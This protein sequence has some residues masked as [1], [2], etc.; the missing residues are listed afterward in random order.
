M[1]N[2]PKW[3]FPY[4]EAVA[5]VKKVEAGSC[6]LSPYGPVCD[7][8][9]RFPKAHGKACKPL[10]V[11]K[12]TI[13]KVSCDRCEQATQGCGWTNSPVSKKQSKG[14]G[15][16]LKRVPEGS[17]D[18]D[19]AVVKPATKKAK[20]TPKKETR[21]AAQKKKSAAPSEVDVTS[22]VEMPGPSQTQATMPGKSTPLFLPSPESDA[23]QDVGFGVA[24]EDIWEEM[25]K[26]LEETPVRPPSAPI[27]GPSK[28][29]DKG[30]GKV[31]VRNTRPHRIPRRIIPVPIYGNEVKTPGLAQPGRFTDHTLPEPPTMD[32]LEAM[33]KA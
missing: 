31:M 12:K 28:P 1:A 33:A 29:K 13:I 3:G 25:G 20:S 24:G 27:A 26:D 5:V 30:K 9:R 4:R 15:S 7:Y 16:G 23:E 18:H 10:I 17:P 6:D 2:H 21:S 14:Q 11:K 22:D 19:D 8:C 32:D